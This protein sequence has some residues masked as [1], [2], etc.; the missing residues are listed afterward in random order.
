MRFLI[1]VLLFSGSAFAG[2]VRHIGGVIRCTDAATCD[3]IRRANHVPLGITSV[4]VDGESIVIR[5]PRANGVI[6]LVVG[7]DET[8][9]QAG[10]ICGASVGLAYSVIRCNVPVVDLAVPGAN[11]WVT[12]MMLD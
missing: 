6:S 7:V 11:I 1:F 9:A 12:G 4:A 8:L 10:V 3:L 5:Y 2:T